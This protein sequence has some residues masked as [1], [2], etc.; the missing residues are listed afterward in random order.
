MKPAYQPKL[1][2]LIIA[3]ALGVT[4]CTPA[5]N[6]TSNANQAAAKPATADEAKAFVAKASEEMA[7]LLIEAQRADWIANTYITEDT[8]ALSAEANE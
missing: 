4:A 5:S 6:S 3:A 2:A 7:A 8:E 1:L